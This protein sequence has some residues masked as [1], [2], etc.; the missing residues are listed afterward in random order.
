MALTYHV[1]DV[2]T[3]RPFGGNPLAVVLGAD[4]LSSTEMQTIAR[5]F[6]LSETVFV[7]ASAS[8]GHT[9][10]IR[11]FTPSRELPFAGHPTLGAAILLA[12]LRS[13]LVNGESDAIIA[14]EQPPSWCLVHVDT[15][16]N[17]LSRCLERD[18]VPLKSVIA[19]ENERSVAASR[20][21][22]TM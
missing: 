18:H 16:F 4:R 19:L 2:F 8:P 1:L 20:A 10:R 17:E 13:S 9:A 6:N 22:E 14:L 11:I 5:E 7:L 21:P 12:E 15:S 3:E